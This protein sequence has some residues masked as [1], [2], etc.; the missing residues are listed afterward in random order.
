MSAD[1]MRF[2]IISGMLRICMLNALACLTIEHFHILSLGRC[3]LPRQ[4][5]RC[6]SLLAMYEPIISI[7]FTS[8]APFSAALGVYHRHNNK[9]MKNIRWWTVHLTNGKIRI[10]PPAKLFLIDFASLRIFFKWQKK[11]QLFNLMQ[12]FLWQRW[13]DSYAISVIFLLKS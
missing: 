2:V 12:I 8:I 13:Y 3:V 11:L 10:L 7:K 6:K 9:W 5:Q 4:A 1:I